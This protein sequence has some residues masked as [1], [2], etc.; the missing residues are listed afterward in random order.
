MGCTA[1][2][3]WNVSTG[4]CLGTLLGH[5][6]LVSEVAFVSAGTKLIS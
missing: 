4:E 2:A 3:I 6:N 5:T 1:I